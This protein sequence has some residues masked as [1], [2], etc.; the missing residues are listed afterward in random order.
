MQTYVGLH[1]AVVTN[2]RPHTMGIGRHLQHSL[3]HPLQTA[4]HLIT[5][6]GSDARPQWVSVSGGP[7]GG[8]PASMFYTS[9]RLGIGA[10]W[11]D[12]VLLPLTTPTQI[13]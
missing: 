10:P 5:I 13:R 1:V 4:L 8:L 7:L 12:K 11:Y 2:R 9:F 6:I 3:L